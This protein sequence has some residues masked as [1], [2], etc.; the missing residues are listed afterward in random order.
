MKPRSTRSIALIAGGAVATSMFLAPAPVRAEESKS[1]KIGAAV[2]GAISI[3]S[4]I[5]GK[6][7]PAVLAGAGAY[8]AYKKSKDARNEDR[9]GDSGNVYPDDVYA[10]NRNDNYYGSY[11]QDNAPYYGGTSGNYP[12]QPYYGDANNY[13][14]QPYYGLRAQNRTSSA[15]KTVR[16]NLSLK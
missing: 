8:Y 13:P 16:P 14:D 5:K 12:D 9:Y 4:V 11:P 15:A 6:E 7:L 1:Y 3:Y 2:L 10:G